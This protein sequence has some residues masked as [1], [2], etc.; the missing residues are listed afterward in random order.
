VPDG[1]SVPLGYADRSS[2]PKES[3]G[4][5]PMSQLAQQPYAGFNMRPIKALSEQ[6]IADLKA[7]RGGNIEAWAQEHGS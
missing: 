5:V 2:P 4:D 3:G 1:H 6:Q 7:G